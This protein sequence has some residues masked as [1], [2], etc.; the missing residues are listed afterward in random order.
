MG[1]TD[2]IGGFSKKGYRDKEVNAFKKTNLRYTE[3]DLLKFQDPTYLGFKLFF[4]FDQPESGLL[5]T[6]AHPNT[7]LKYL[8]DRGYNQRAAYLKQ[9]VTLLQ[10]INSECPWFWQS[11][12]GLDE[13]WKHGFN[14][15]EFVAGL[16]LD[17]KIS[18]NTLDESV[19]LRMTALM[20]LYRKACFDWPNRREVV[21]RNLRFFSV[22]IYCYESR[23]INRNVSLSTGAAALLDIANGADPLSTMTKEIVKMQKLLGSDEQAFDPITLKVSA[24]NDNISRVMFDFNYCEWLPDE[25]GVVVS[26]LSN[27]ELALKAQKLVFSY[28]NVAEDNVYRMHS[29]AKVTDVFVGALDALALDTPG[30]MVKAVALAKLNSKAAGVLNNLFLGNAYGF[31][32]ITAA[33][34][35]LTDPKTV[36]GV[37]KDI[38][39]TS[40]LKNDTKDVTNGRLGKSFGLNTA[41]LTNNKTVAFPPNPD[42][43]YPSIAN[44]K[45]INPSGNYVTGSASIANR[46]DTNPSGN[47]VTGSASITNGKDINPSGNPYPSSSSLNNATNDVNKSIPDN[48]YPAS[49]SLNNATNDVNKPIGNYEDGSKSL[50]NVD[51]KPSGNYEEGSKSLNNVDG[52]VSGNVYE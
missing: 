52:I 48:P 5:S 45:D 51:G 30:D 43:F 20:D 1:L 12:E 23:S 41:S 31:T 28:R 16:T 37:V 6:I 3:N 42:V 27:A 32:P 34:S 22:A 8:E 25:S 40:S 26:G 10:R 7:A 15:E 24:I 47:Y 33:N 46:K 19:D 44:G 29:D 4:L 39:P 11:V 9:F 18:I 35:I 17:R 13:A 38:L 50:N 14:E 49:S 36:V 2:I 21:P